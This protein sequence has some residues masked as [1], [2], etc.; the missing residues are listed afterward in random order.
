MNLIYPIEKG[1]TIYSISKCEYCDKSKL[2]LESIGEEINIINVD[3]VIK[4]KYTKQKFLDHIYLMTG[5]NIKYFPMIFKDK[6]YIG[7]FKEL[8]EYYGF[9]GKIKEEIELNSEDF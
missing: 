9:D 4:K 6:E 7:G 5:Q 8:I 1:W 2:Y 3:D